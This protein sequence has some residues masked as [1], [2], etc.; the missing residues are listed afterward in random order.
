MVS[1]R[2]LKDFVSGTQ[3]ATIDAFLASVNYYAQGFG[4]NRT[5]AVSGA[6]VVAIDDSLIAG[7]VAIGAN[8]TN[9]NGGVVVA[10]NGV[11]TITG[12]ITTVLDGLGNIANLCE[13]RDSVTN[14]P[15]LSG[16]KEV[17]GL[18]QVKSGVSDGD[19]IGASG[20]ENI[21][22]SFVTLSNTDVL[23]LV[24]LTGTY[25]FTYYKRF[26]KRFIPDKTIIG[27]ASAIDILA[28]YLPTIEKLV[29]T[30]QYALNEV[31][32]LSS[33]AGVSAGTG[34]VSGTTAVLPAS[35]NLFNSTTTVIVRRNGVGQEKGVE[36]IWD[37]T[38]SLHF[39]DV[40]EVGEVLE[41]QI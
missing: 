20:S 38:G 24:S 34:T 30:A 35:A 17:F 14:D 8:S 5:V 18:L 7:T 15:V 21:M 27:K 19:A 1:V 40:I 26:A 23:T 6:N 36:V 13:I 9:N 3:Y 2:Q 33:G 11:N 4:T 41:F 29:V 25:E 28:P 31:I 37:S 16:G 22:I 10:Q 39:A 32:T 12:A